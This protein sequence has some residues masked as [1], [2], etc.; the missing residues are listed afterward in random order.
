MISVKVN[1]TGLMRKLKA[2]KSIDSELD[3]LFSET[4]NAIVDKAKDR[5]PVRTGQ[6]R[7]STKAYREGK[8]WS[9]TAAAPYAM[10]VNY[11][12]ARIAG[13][14]F[15]TGAASEELKKLRGKITRELNKK[16]KG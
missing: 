3:S 10:M 7:D 12:I 9:V 6:L 13:T 5:A 4:A 16:I 11:G 15:L 1:K 8:K 2:L 14:F